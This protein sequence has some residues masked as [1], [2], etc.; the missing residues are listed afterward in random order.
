[1]VRNV[2]SPSKEKGVIGIRCLHYS[3]MSFNCVVFKGNL[4]QLLA[5]IC[6]YLRF[7]SAIPPLHV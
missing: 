7:F 4:A 2:L 6:V 1:M 5:I 3:L